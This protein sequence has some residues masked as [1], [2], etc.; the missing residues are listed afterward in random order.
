MPCRQHGAGKM[1]CRAALNEP[2]ARTVNQS[3]KSENA[4]PLETHF[5]TCAVDHITDIAEPPK[6][7][8]SPDRFLGAELLALGLVSSV[9]GWRL[10]KT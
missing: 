8:V 10:L 1:F 6:S 9:A 2:A 3:T 4:Q 7:P 5:W